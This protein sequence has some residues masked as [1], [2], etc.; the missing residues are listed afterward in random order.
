MKDITIGGV[1]KIKR[2]IPHRT[3]NGFI[4]KYI[5]E[6]KV[7]GIHSKLSIK[8][9]KC[10]LKVQL[11]KGRL[12]KRGDYSREDDVTSSY[13]IASVGN[14]K[15]KGTIVFLVYSDILDLKSCVKTGDQE[16]CPINSSFL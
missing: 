15:K 1:Y 12:Y 10:K 11:I 2:H 5:Q 16:F 8:S 7:L 13:D 14:K 6:V 3:S 4:I 9:S